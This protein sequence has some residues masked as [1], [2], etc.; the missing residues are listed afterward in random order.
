MESRGPRGGWRVSWELGQDREAHRDWPNGQE[1]LGERQSRG[2][3]L[4]PENALR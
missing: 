2:V 4:R 3:G 1:G